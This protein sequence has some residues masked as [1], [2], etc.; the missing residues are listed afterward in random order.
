MRLT[1]TGKRRINTVV[2][3]EAKEEEALA[4]ALVQVVEREPGPDRVVA[5]PERDPVA[6]LQAAAEPRTVPGE[7]LELETVPVAAPELGIAPVVARELGIALAAELELETVPVAAPELELAPVVEV[8]APDPLRAQPAVALRIKSVT[9]LHHRGLP[10]PRVAALAAVAAETTRE[11]AAPGAAIAWGEAV[12]AGA[13]VVMAEVV[14]VVSAAVG[15]VA[16][17]AADAVVVA[18]AAVAAAAVGDRRNSR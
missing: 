12:T 6:V 15:G 11:P 8:L 10:L 18:D 17:V 4:L 3:L 1:G 13:A 14:A 9:A 5:E 2:K 16:A 7:V